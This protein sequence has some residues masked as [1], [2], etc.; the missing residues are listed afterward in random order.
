MCGGKEPG[1]RTCPACKGWGRDIVTRCPQLEI[2]EGCWEMFGAA[3]LAKQGCWP[4]AGGWLDQTAVCVDG[5]RILNAER[6]KHQ[7]E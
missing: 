7:A 3:D 5:V 6:Q 2:P 1:R 4:V